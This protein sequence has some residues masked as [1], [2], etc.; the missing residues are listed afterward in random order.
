[1][2]PLSTQF[3]SYFITSSVETNSSVPYTVALESL[4]FSEIASIFYKFTEQ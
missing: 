4:S 2:Q 3:V 1:M